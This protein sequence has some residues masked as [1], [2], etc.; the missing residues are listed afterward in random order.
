M[1]DLTAPPSPL[2][3]TP[4]PYNKNTI[5]MLIERL[6]PY[7]LAKAEMLM[8]MNHRPT[9]ISHLMFILEDLEERFPEPA[10]QQEII[11]V[12]EGVLGA[13]DGEAERLAMSE[14]AKGARERQM[15]AEAREI[16]VQEIKAREMEVDGPS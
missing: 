12:I 8:I 6:R 15:E 5:R 14:G 16:G 10:T 13:P 4:F 2:G 7:D 3:N 9:H 1:A 11:D